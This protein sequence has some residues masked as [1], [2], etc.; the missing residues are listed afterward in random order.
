[1]WLK[2][3]VILS[4]LLTIIKLW[5]KCYFLVQNHPET[6]PGQNFKGQGHFGKIKSQIKVMQTYNSQ[7][8]S[9]QGINFLQPTV[10]EI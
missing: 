6:L 9:L 1:M 7:P 3:A 4:A 10:S 5:N 2:H 8:M